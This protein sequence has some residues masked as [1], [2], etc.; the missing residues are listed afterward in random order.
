MN[1]PEAIKQLEE[2]KEC[3]NKFDAVEI[4]KEDK[5]A[6]NITLELLKEKS[7]SNQVKVNKEIMRQRKRV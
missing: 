3:C 5:E 6:I 2:S 4:M 1:I 7:V